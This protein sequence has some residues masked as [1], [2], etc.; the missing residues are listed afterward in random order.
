VKYQDYRRFGSNVKILYDGKEIPKAD[1]KTPPDQ[2]SPNNQ[3]PNNPNQ[4]QK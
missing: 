4:P 2:Q 1:Q 3:S